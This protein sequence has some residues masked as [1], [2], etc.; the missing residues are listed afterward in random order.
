MD[1]LMTIGIIK[2]YQTVNQVSDKELAK[3]VGVTERTICN[4]KNDS[5]HIPL[6]KLRIMCK[7][8][9]IPNWEKVNMI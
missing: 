6:G 4:W 2:K 1:N 5:T 3:K 8:L 9:K 7:M